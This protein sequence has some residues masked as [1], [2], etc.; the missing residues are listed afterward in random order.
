M[1]SLKSAFC[2]LSLLGMLAIPQAL[3]AAAQNGAIGG[4]YRVHQVNPNGSTYDGTLYI[5]Q[6]HGGRMFWDNHS[7]T[8]PF[9]CYYNSG[10]VNFDLKYPGGLEGHYQANITPDGGSLFDGETTSNQTGKDY[11]GKW[12]AQRTEGLGPNWS[13][14]QYFGR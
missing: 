10:W 5:S 14:N 1:L 3:P 6:T 13:G 2:K 12:T 4:T 9:Q 11:K 7:Q 8:E